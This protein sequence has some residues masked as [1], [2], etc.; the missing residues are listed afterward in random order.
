MTDETDDTGDDTG[1]A[2]GE[3]SGDEDTGDDTAEAGGDERGHEPDEDT[4]ED[5]GDDDNGDEETGEE[6]GDDADAGESGDDG[7]EGRGAATE[8]SQERLDE[9]GDHIAQA[10]SRA[11]ETVGA[12]EEKYYDSGDDESE[13][14][15]DQTIT[16]PG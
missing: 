11:E 7:A 1:A 9:L 10:R 14:E 16:P 15:D 2:G 13:R 3:D 6:T 8:L 12:P 5:T 4:S